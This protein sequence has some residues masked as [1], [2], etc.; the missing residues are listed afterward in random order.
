MCRAMLITVLLAMASGCNVEVG[1]PVRYTLTELNQHALLRVHQLEVEFQGIAMQPDCRID[2]TFGIM[3]QGYRDSR[4]WNVGT[5]DHD[6]AWSW[7]GPTTS[8]QIDRHSFQYI[9]TGYSATG[10][11]LRIDGQDFAT[12]EGN[13]IV[14]DPSGK[15]VPADAD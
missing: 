12:A 2:S 11:K 10:L 14:V 15:V 8:F 6:I 7:D 1:I 4:R 5:C 3:P 9:A 13:R